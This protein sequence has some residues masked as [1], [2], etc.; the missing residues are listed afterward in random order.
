MSIPAA[1]AAFDHMRSARS[2]ADCPEGRRGSGTSPGNADHGPR[3]QFEHGLGVGPSGE[4]ARKVGDRQHVLAGDG[5]GGPEPALERHG[6]E[7]LGRR[8]TAATH[9]GAA[10][11]QALEQADGRHVLHLGLARAAVDVLH[12]RQPF[13]GQEPRGGGVSLDDPG[14]VPHLGD[15]LVHQTDTSRAP[16]RIRARSGRA[17]PPSSPPSSPRP[18]TVGAGALPLEDRRPVADDDELGPGQERH[19]A[20]R[21]CLRTRSSG[22][23]GCTGR[24]PPRPRLARRDPSARRPLPPGRRSSGS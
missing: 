4:P 16:A 6:Q 3:P 18:T 19:G 11:G 17:T 1:S 23:P 12:V 22:P 24:G 5:H 9:V 14:D 13:G 10:L 15:G 2:T 20:R 8:W 21:A 7:V